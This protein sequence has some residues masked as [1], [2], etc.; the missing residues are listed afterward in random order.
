MIFGCLGNRWYLA[1][2]EI[3]GLWLFWKKVVLAAWEI[4]GLWLFGK[5]VVFGCLGNR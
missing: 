5:K 2:W 4:G 3:G 1:A